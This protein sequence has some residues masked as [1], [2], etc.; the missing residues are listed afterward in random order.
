MTVSPALV[1]ASSALV[2]VSPALVA[3][4]AAALCACH[5]TKLAC[6]RSAREVRATARP[7]I[8]PNSAATNPGAGD[9]AAGRGAGGGAAGSGAAGSAAGIAAASAAVVSGCSPRSTSD[10]CEGGAAVNVGGRGDGGAGC[11]PA[12]LPRPSPAHAVHISK[13]HPL[14]HTSRSSDAGIMR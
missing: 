14:G 7:A 1:A 4:R 12:R 9:G 8:L 13:S 11:E 5:S 3:R 2:A 6:A 10:C